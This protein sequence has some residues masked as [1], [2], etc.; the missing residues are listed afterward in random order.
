MW[1][2][3]FLLA[4]ILI[5]IT[6]NTNAQI[7]E[8]KCKRLNLKKISQENIFNLLKKFNN[9]TVS[10][11]QCLEH[12]INDSTE[13]QIQNKLLNV[14]WNIS[15]KTNNPRIKHLAINYFINNLNNDVRLATTT[16]RYLTKFNKNLF[17]TAQVNLLEKN[18]DKSYYS[19][20]ILLL[21][22]IGNN[23]TSS[24]IKNYFPSTRKFSKKEIWA[25]YMAL[26]RLGDKNSI[27]F[28][29]RMISKQKI[30]DNVVDNLYPDLVYISQ[31]QAYDVLTS[32][33]LSDEA[34]CSSSNPN[35]DSKILCAYRV[36][37]LIANRIKNFPIKTL[38]SGDLNVTDYSKALENVRI[39]LNSNKNNYQIDTEV[40]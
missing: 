17:D 9:D 4:F 21:G 19:E 35:V 37:E 13:Y 12:K 18:L 6:L 31:K 29:I 2:N 25:S 39:W 15:Y 26:A 24:I 11:I 16:I 32:V 38:P 5:T 8:Q 40:Y 7:N 36:I 1:K 3:K 27:E 22:Y 14:I 33:I 30:G 28:C 34:K 10:F 20:L 23:E